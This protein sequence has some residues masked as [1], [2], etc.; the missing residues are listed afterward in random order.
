MKRIYRFLVLEVIIAVC[1][2]RS[3]QALDEAHQYHAQWTNGLPAEDTFF[4]LAV[5]LQAPSF[6]L[7]YK[8][9]GINLFIG[10]PGGSTLAEAVTLRSY[11]MKTFCDQNAALLDRISMFQG[12]VVGWMHVDE[13][14]NAQWNGTGYDPCISPTT[15]QSLYNTWTTR[16]PT[17]PIL[18][19]L[20]QG[21]ANI[22]WVGRGTCT[23][24][25]RMYPEYIKG[26]DYVCFD[27][28]PVNSR[29]PM[30]WVPKG[31][32][33][34]ESWSNHQKPTL[35]WIECTRI[36][37]GDPKPTPAQTKS[38]VWMAIIHGANGIGYFC[39]SFVTGA[40]SPQALLEDPTMLQAVTDLN[41]RITSLGPVINSP[42]VT[43][44]VSV[45]SSNGSVPVDILVKEYQGGLYIFAAAMRGSATSATFT[46]N[47]PPSNTVTV[48]DESRSKT[49]SGGNFT[50]AFTGYG[51]HLYQL[52]GTPVVDLGK[53][54]SPDYRV[55]AG[56][57]PFKVRTSVVLFTQGMEGRG[58]ATI[59]TVSGI[60]VRS[61]TLEQ[62]V[63]DWNGTDD[64]GQAVPEGFYTI[65][66]LY[67]GY[68]AVCTVL[69]LR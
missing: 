32:D 33:S 9:A 24:N 20:G 38:E 54:V 12:T 65:K 34:L 10:L 37:D 18:L 7:Q 62:G 16:D 63:A 57:N 53:L 48:L 30:E 15:I 42:T 41:A 11:G 23:G 49:L 66:A 60:K 59:H 8:A 25:W 40:T 6:S 56:P 46:I 55:A 31:I 19:N 69:K 36:G 28:Y 51:I 64:N 22:N 21:V 35:A 61:L 14:D 47:N 29:Y 27:V 17:R 5:W 1:F 4:P 2:I 44:K 43:G 58:T 26:T 50:D 39:H 67:R 68:Q 3:G 45:T 52:G 13:P